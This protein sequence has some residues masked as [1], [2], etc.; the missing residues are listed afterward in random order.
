MSKQKL[1]VQVLQ[2]QPPRVSSSHGSWGKAFEAAEKLHTGVAH[3][4]SDNLFGNEVCAKW[5]PA[6]LF[7]AELHCK[8]P[9]ERSEIDAIGTCSVS[10]RTLELSN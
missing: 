5:M 10:I 1:V 3:T 4:H 2:G 9:I 7:G 6:G 8:G